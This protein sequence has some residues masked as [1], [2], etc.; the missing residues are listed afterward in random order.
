MNKGESTLNK[1]SITW[2][3]GGLILLIILVG[4]I[5]RIILSRKVKKRTDRNK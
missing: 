3:V 5:L 2:V 4:I 1:Y